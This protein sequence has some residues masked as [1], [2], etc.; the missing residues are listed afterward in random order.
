[1]APVKAQK[2]GRQCDE[3]ALMNMSL[4]E[5]SQKI[6]NVIFQKLDIMQDELFGMLEEKDQRI[7]S[8]EGEVDA[9]KCAVA[10][11]EERV[12]DGDAYERRDTVVFSGEAVPAASDGENCGQLAC[13][14]LRNALNMEVSPSAISV[15]H[16]IGSK[17]VT[18]GPDKR[19]IIVKLCRREMKRD[20]LEGCRRVKPQNLYINESLTPVRSTIMYVMRKARRQFPDRI[21]GCNSIDGKVFVWVKPPNPS[22]PQPRNTRTSVNT[23]QQ[24]QKFCSDILD[25][26]LTTFL[27]RWP[28]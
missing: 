4:S 28:H 20:I 19:S 1:M 12:D 27:D 15:A 2:F 22:A 26:P 7:R 23:Y 24:L 25:T 5:E 16:R 21:S 18:Q 13:N 10:R 9:L 8:L 14:M 11:L 6:V 17:P 3:Q